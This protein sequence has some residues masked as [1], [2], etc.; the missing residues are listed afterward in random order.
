MALNSLARGDANED[1]DLD[2]LILTRG[3]TDGVERAAFRAVR[4]VERELDYPFAVCPHVM[5]KQHF[6]D[7]VRR[8]RLFAR[9]QD[10][11]LT[12]R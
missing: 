12:S 2:L 9:V 3:E 10:P 5:T 8:E 1:S 4:V 11:P 6:D 7:L